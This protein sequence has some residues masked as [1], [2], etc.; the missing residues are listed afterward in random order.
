LN[1][2]ISVVNHRYKIT[3]LEFPQKHADSAIIPEVSQAQA[4][5]LIDQ[6][7]AELFCPINLEILKDP[8]ILE[9]RQ[10]YSKEAIEQYFNSL[11]PR[12]KSPITRQIV[13]GDTIPN[14]LV[15]KII[16]KT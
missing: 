9:D 12:K 1:N 16:E 8:V 4:A 2:H 11:G 3:Q 14:I 5:E 13:S 15:R 10:T 7:R 6:I